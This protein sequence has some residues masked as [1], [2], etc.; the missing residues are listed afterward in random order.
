MKPRYISTRMIIALAAGLCA[1]PQR[2]SYA[3]SGEGF[4][5]VDAFAA[6]NIQAQAAPAVTYPDQF[7]AA[8]EALAQGLSVK[9]ASATTHTFPSPAQIREVAA[10]KPAHTGPTVRRIKSPT[11]DDGFKDIPMEDYEAAPA[12]PE[13][14]TADAQVKPATV[15]QAPAKVVSKT[16]ANAKPMLQPQDDARVKELEAQLRETKTQLAAAELEI[17]RLSG[18][19]QSNSRARLNLP[20]PPQAASAPTKL[21][22]L[23]VH[24]EPK[25]APVAEKV[26]DHVND[27][28]VATVSVDKAD[29]RLGPGKNHTALMTLRRGSRLAIEARQGEWYRVFAP[30]GQRAWIHSSLVQFGPGAASLNDGSSVKVRGFK[31]GLE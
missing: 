17:S 20:Q 4:E 22:A 30:N 26:A 9:P 28:Q 12:K 25:P 3:Q 13:K 27:L 23:P 5:M 11:L 29:L 16:Q 15:K 1:C 6:P 31:A 18:I 21:A 7:K 19:I 8:Q 24:A 10:V 14:P 2:F